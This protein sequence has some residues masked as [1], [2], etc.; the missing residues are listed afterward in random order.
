M[1]CDFCQEEFN[2]PWRIGFTYEGI[3]K[4]HNPPE[5]ISKRLEE[6][7]SGEFFN[8]CRKHHKD[9]H[10]EIIKI[11]NKNSN[12]LKFINSE[13]WICERMTLEQIKKSQKEIYDFTKEWIKRGKNGDT[14]TITS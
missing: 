8:L 1:E 4:H 3:D 2:K 12:S 7:W 10:C 11:L 5:F 9:L 6:G 13:H 14:K